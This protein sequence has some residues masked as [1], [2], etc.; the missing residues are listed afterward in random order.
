[1]SLQ[2]SVEWLLGKKVD[3]NEKAKDGSTALMRACKDS[4]N[5]DILQV[6]KSIKKSI[7]LH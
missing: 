7:V 1:M 5:V 4:G 2:A 6:S 3:V